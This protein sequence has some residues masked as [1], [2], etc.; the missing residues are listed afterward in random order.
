[1][2]KSLL[3]PSEAASLLLLAKD[4]RPAM[5]LQV[6]IC[7]LEDPSLILEQVDRDDVANKL[8]LAQQQMMEQNSREEA[9]HKSFKIKELLMHRDLRSVR[10][11]RKQWV[12]H[13]KPLEFKEPL[14][15]EFHRLKRFYLFLS[16]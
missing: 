16:F 15:E 4:S 10:D 11:Q 9:C 5:K 13:I 3:F 14:H 6:M 7:F 12:S 2:Q 8:A 1:M